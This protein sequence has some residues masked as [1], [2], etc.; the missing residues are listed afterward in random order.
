M[1]SRYKWTRI[2]FLSCTIFFSCTINP[3]WVRVLLDECDTRANNEWVFT[4]EHGFIIADLDGVS[5]KIYTNKTKLSVSVHGSFFYVDGKRFV[6]KQWALFP[7][8]GLLEWNGNFYKGAFTFC[9]QKNKKALLIN[10]VDLQ[11]YIFAVLRS[12]SW[13]GWPLEVNKVFAVITRSYVMSKVQEAKRLKRPYH[14]KNTKIHQTYNGHT[15]EKRNDKALQLA[16]KYTKGLFLAYDGKPIV[17]MFDSCC[18]GITPSKMDG[19][20]FK[21]A[22][23]LAR[24]YPCKHCKR[25]RLYSWEVEYSIDEWTQLLKKMFPDLKKVRGIWVAKRDDA[26]LIQEVVIKGAKKNF[27]LSG[28][29]LYS[30]LDAVKSFYFSVHKKGR[31]IV[32]KGRGYGHHLGLCQWGAREMVRDKWGYKKII[33]FY[34][35]NV[36]FAKLA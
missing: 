20:D 21:K 24:D 8:Q 25:C 1:T 32:L 4:S 31:N 36:S 5:K 34:Y 35:P 9:F 23:Y 11:D 18:G 26:G 7:K 15:F 33:Q 6:K 14:I 12:E 22:P 29:K 30:L 16:V 10:L 2:L 19:V 3:F 13:P 27:S 17:A 28:K